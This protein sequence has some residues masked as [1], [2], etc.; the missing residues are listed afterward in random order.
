MDKHLLVIDITNENFCLGYKLID[1]IEEKKALTCWPLRSEAKQS[2]CASNGSQYVYC[3]CIDCSLFLSSDCSLFFFPL[4]NHLGAPTC[5][6]SCSGLLW[7]QIEDVFELRWLSALAQAIVLVKRACA[8]D[9]YLFFLTQ[10]TIT[11]ILEMAIKGIFEMTI[12]S[13]CLLS[14][15]ALHIRHIC[16]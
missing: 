14:V 8:W 12:T 10:M 3:P 6:S 7:G 16:Q 4:K 11:S 5:T 15:N 2:G 9:D 13:I 1:M